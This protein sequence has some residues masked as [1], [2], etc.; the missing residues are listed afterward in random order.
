MPNTAASKFEMALCPLKVDYWNAISREEQVVPFLMPLSSV[1]SF[2][3][4]GC[5]DL[6]Q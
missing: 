5:R 6:V 4:I 3:S 1:C 2:T